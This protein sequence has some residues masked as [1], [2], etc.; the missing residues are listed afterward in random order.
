MNDR[1]LRRSLAST[2]WLDQVLT[3]QPDAVRARVL[4]VLVHYGIAPDHEFFM[5]FVTIGHLL[6]LVEE[7]PEQWQSISDAFG[8]ELKQWQTTNLQTLDRLTRQAELIVELSTNT[9]KL[10]TTLTELTQVC[11]QLMMSLQQSNQTLTSSTTQLQKSVF[12][13]TQLLQQMR[14]EQSGLYQRL[15]RLENMVHR[16]QRSLQTRPQN[17]SLKVAGA[18]ISGVI[19]AGIGLV[20]WQQRVETERVQWLL[21]K[22]NRWECQHGIKLPNSPECEGL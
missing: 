18:L 17:L 13:S 4:D 21:E 5:I 9:S 3:N 20:Y 2:S 19:L 8:A 22:A 7:R 11:T 10:S 14:R 6:A 15:D 1:E 12:A 16:T